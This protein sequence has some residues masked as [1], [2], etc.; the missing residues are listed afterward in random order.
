MLLDSDSEADEVEE[1]YDDLLSTLALAY[2][3]ISDSRC[4]NRG[5]RGSAGR[6]RI[7]GAIAEYFS[8]PDRSFLID[9]CM[10][11]GSFW[12][13]VDLLKVGG[14]KYRCQSLGSDAFSQSVHQQVAVALYI[15]GAGPS[16]TAERARIK[17]NIAVCLLSCIFYPAA[18]GPKG[19]GSGGGCFTITG[20]P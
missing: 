3:A 9:F 17:L 7:E 6:L 12:A 13:L 10:R 18:C 14:D 11:R 16:S 20:F 19:H 8:Y 15:P 5:T 2:H 1:D 4:I